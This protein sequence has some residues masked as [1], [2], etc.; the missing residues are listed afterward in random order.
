MYLVSFSRRA[1]CANHFS[2]QRKNNQRCVSDSFAYN[3][4]YCCIFW[5]ADRV[6]ELIIPNIGTIRAA[7]DLASQYADEIKSIKA[8]VDRQKQVIDFVAMAAHATDRVMTELT[9]K[10]AKATTQLQ[11]VAEQ[12]ATAQQLTHEIQQR[13]EYAEVARLGLD[14]LLGLAGTGLKETT[15][16]NNILGKYIHA[17]PNTEVRTECTP[18]AQK[19]YT[20]A[21]NLE[22][23]FPFSYYYRALC[24]QRTRSG[25]WQHDID[26]ARRILL[27]TTQIPGHNKGHDELLKLLDTGKFP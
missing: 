15:P 14:G 11:Q 6:T 27:I 25:D 18:E 1:D 7:A 26:T 9:E 13:Q 5:M 4:F 2:S 21:I 12:L 16:L 17:D 8:D 24:N 23:K 3:P 19:A 10:N 20:D 22:N